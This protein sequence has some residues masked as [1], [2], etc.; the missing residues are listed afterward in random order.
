MTGT[1]EDWRT[2]DRRWREQELDASKPEDRAAAIDLIYEIVDK[3][4][5]PTAGVMVAVPREYPPGGSDYSLGHWVPLGLFEWDVEEAYGNAFGGTWNPVEDEVVR[6]LADHGLELRS[7][8][9]VRALHFSWIGAEAG[10]R[11]NSILRSLNTA[12]EQGAEASR[13]EEEFRRLAPL[14]DRRLPTGVVSMFSFVLFQLSRA[15]GHE[16]AARSS[17]GSDPHVMTILKMDARSNPI[18][19]SPDSN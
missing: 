19:A 11:I 7:R 8:D 13:R 12:L 5:E 1:G 15:L 17:E 10:V 4:I 14:L 18:E 2:F 16:L 9:E 3:F 6:L